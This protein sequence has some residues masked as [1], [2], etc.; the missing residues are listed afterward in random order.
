MFV[1]V[2]SDYEM[3]RVGRESFP[4]VSIEVRMLDSATGL[5]V[6]SASQ[7]RRG[8]PVTPIFGWGEVHTLGE[9]TSKVCRDLLDTLPKD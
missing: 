4:L 9:L 1:G 3:V 5:V 8:G 2:V 7:T 6:G